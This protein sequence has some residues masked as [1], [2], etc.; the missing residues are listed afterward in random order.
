MKSKIQTPLNIVILW[1]TFWGLVSAF[2]FTGLFVPSAQTYL[3]LSIFIISLFIGGK[4]VGFFK[5]NTTPILSNELKVERILEFVFNLSSAFL[6]I[7]L[8]ILLIRS[9]F[10]VHNSFTPSVYRATAFSTDTVV[11]TLFKNRILENLYFLISSTLLFFFALFGLVD[12]WK[13]GTFSKIFIAFVLNGMDAVIRLGRVNLYLMIVLFIIVFSLSD[14]KIITFLKKKKKQVGLI[15]IMF[16]CL[17]YIGKQRGYSP[18]QQFKLFVVDYHTVGFT[19][20]DHEL[21]NPTSQL[22]TKRTYGRL[23]IGGLETFGTIFIRRFN[24]NYY[25]PALENSIR[26]AK[27]SVVVGVENPPT[28]IFNGIKVY[29]SFYTLLYTFYSDGGFFGIIVGGSLLG[30]LL[31]FFFLKWKKEKST[32]DALLLVLFISVGILSI[33]MS[34]LEIMRT[35]SVLIF[36][37]YLKYISKN[38][39]HDANK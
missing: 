22:N 9:E 39:V 26:M 6:F 11:G 15:F 38:V 36:F 24:E 8:V 23:T 17:L 12:F 33:F 1:W 10:L 21:K 3:I 16:L 5:K 2:S 20:F 14:Q 34:Q 37:I 4:A 25:S 19:L 13:K 7:I 29:N 28:I 32:V 27:N 31:E 30:F 18:S 35:W